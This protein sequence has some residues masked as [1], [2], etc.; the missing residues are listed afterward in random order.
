[1]AQWRARNKAKKSRRPFAKGG[2]GLIKGVKFI[3]ATGERTQPSKKVRAALHYLVTVI[4]RPINIKTMMA[5]AR[6][7]SLGQDAP[8]Y[9]L[10]RRSAALRLFVSRRFRMNNLVPRSTRRKHLMAF[11]DTFATF[12]FHSESRQMLLHMN[13]PVLLL[14]PYIALSPKSFQNST[15]CGRRSSTIRP[16]NPSNS[17]LG[18]HC[19]AQPIVK[20]VIT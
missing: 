20:K 11:L 12:E 18:L 9:P 10:P 7:R 16:T 1:M 4:G 13:Q 2:I 17:I 14:P 19:Q 8:P 6:L 5:R 15:L 3:N